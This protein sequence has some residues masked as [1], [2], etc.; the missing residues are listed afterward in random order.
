M[1]QSFNERYGEATNIDLHIVMLVNFAEAERL[2]FAAAIILIYGRYGEK[3][4]PLRQ[5]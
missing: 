2:E 1:D 3:G 4:R 5:R